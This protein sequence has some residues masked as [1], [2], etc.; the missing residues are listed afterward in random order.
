MTTSET[1]PETTLP[2]RNDERLFHDLFSPA[3]IVE[4][5][6]RVRTLVEEHLRPFVDGIAHGDEQVDGFPTEAFAAMA[7]A[8]FFRIPFAAP[9]GA[10]LEHPATAT[11]VTVE[12]LAYASN[13]L[14][15]VY[16]VHCILAGHAISFADEA[17]RE[18]WMTPLTSGQVVGAFATSEPASSTDLSPSAIQT[19]ARR[20]G[21]GLVI[22]GHK[23]W[24]SNSPVADFVVM[25]CRTDDR[26]LSLILI[27]LKDTPGVRVGRP[28]RKLGNRG[29]LTADVHLKAFGCQ[30]PTWSVHPG[31]D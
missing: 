27:P 9:H 30:H 16:D 10:G 29:Q 18:Q 26:E 2:A 17:L 15:A 21:D 14:A 8:E 5:R 6:R 19:V 7:D 22:D 24:I 13:S 12:E 3:E 11:A 28:D 23:R 25:L 20:E 1:R 31:R 4:V